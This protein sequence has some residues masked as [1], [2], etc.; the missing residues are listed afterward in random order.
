VTTRDLE[1]EEYVLHYDWYTT[2]HNETATELLEFLQL[3]MH[4]NGELTPFEEG[5]VYPYF[6]AE[7]KRAVRKAFEI[8]AS[9]RTWKHVQH[10]FDNIEESA[11]Y[12]ESE[13]AALELS[14]QRPPLNKLV[15]GQS[16]TDIIGDVQW[17]MDFAIVGYPKTATSTKTR[18]LAQ[19]QEIQM[20]EHEVYHMKDGEPAEMV[21][22]LYKLPAGNQ[23]KRGYKAPR[24]I[25]NFRALYA[26]AYF[27]PKTKLIIG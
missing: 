16:K 1:L 12:D 27:W 15:K 2:R 9:P 23:Y 7:E 3:P 24:D 25:H 8:M 13:A 21:R 18:W 19:H 10:Y 20:N 14:L 6:T 4:E 17:L 11:L 22:E 5:K 26:F